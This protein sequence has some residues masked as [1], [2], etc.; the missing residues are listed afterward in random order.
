MQVRSAVLDQS[1]KWKIDARFNRSTLRKRI[2]RIHLYR[3]RIEAFDLDAIEL[4]K[5]MLS[6]VA[7]TE[8]VIVYLDPP[9]YKKGNELYLNSYSHKDHE[10]LAQFLSKPLPFQWIMT[11][12]NVPEIRRLYAQFPKHSFS[13]SYS[14]YDSRGGK[15][16]I[17]P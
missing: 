2:E 7:K 14:A 15:R 10:R 9:Y 13:L 5:R 12:D 17:D 16:V 3:D 1:G 11:Y 4:L 8:A 6:K